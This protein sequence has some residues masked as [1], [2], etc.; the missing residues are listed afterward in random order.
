MA[1]AQEVQA[2]D[3][4]AKAQAQ[5]KKEQGTDRTPTRTEESRLILVPE[6]RAQAPTRP[7]WQA[8]RSKAAQLQSRYPASATPEERAIH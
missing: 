1:K 4:A 5:V 3:W 8:C 2:A 7:L 6:E